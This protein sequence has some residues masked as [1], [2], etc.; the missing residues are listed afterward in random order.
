MKLG[1]KK[2]MSPNEKQIDEGDSNSKSKKSKASLSVIQLF[3]FSTMRDKLMILCA[4]VGSAYSGA[5]LPI[6]VIIFGDVMRKM[7]ESMIFKDTLLDNTRSMILELVYLGTS[8][9]VAT[10]VATAFWIISG[11]NQARRIRMK[12]LHAVLR[13][14]MS[15]FDS[16]EEG[17]LNTRLAGDTQTIQDGISE[18]FGTLTMSVAQF[19]SGYIVAFIKGWRMAL[20]ML[21][22][23]PLLLAS[24]AVMGIFITRFTLKVQRSYALA[25]TVAEQVFSGLRTVYSFS[26]QGRFAD[27]FERELVH[28]RKMGI[29]RGIVLGLGFGSFM[30]VLFLTYGLSF[31]Y[32]SRL[33]KQGEFDGATVLVV[34]FS[35]MMGSMAL[36]QLPPSLS[37]VSSAC[38][39]ARNIFATIDRVP[40]IDPDD[41]SFGS[42]TSPLQGE[43]EFKNVFFKYPTRPNL[44]ILKDLSLKIKQGM[45]VAF[46]GPSGSGKSTVIQL[47][48]RFYDPIAGQ[49]LL[50]GRDLRSYSVQSLRQQIGVV[51]QEPVLFN[52]TIKH[53]LL[54][55]IDDT[56]SVSHD[57][58]IEACKKAN[59]HGFIS[60]LP[61]GYNTLVGSGMLSGGQKQRVAIARA[62]LKN[63][64]LLLL[65]EATSALDTQSERLVQHALDAAAADRTTLVVAHRLSTIR[66][67]D[68]IVV[69]QQ[70]D[71]VEKGT[72]QELIELGGIYADL[73]K[74]QE[75]ATIQSSTDVTD[76]HDD[77]E[78]LL[79]QEK[80]ELYLNE[81]I[82][83]DQQSAIS[84]V[85]SSN[86]V[87]RM[88]T[89]SSVDAFQLK[90]KREKQDRKLKKAQKTPIFKVFRQMRS[91]WPLMFL[92]CLGAAVAGSIFP[93]FAYLFSQVIVILINPFRRNEIDQGPVQGTNFYAFFF[94]VMAVIA[95]IA[96][97]TQIISFEVAG[98]RYTERLRT[99]M[100]QAYMRQEVGYF[101]QEENNVGA[102]T[103]KIAVD[104]KNVNELVT[105]VWGD[106]TQLLVTVIVGLS[107]SFA[108]SWL[109]TLIVLCAAPFIV[110]ATGSETRVRQGYQDNTKKANAESGEVAGEAIKEIRTISALNKQSYFE[111]KYEKAIEYPHRLAV[112]KALLASIGQALVRGSNL[113]LN[114]LALYAGVRLIMD[115]WITFEEMFVVLSEIMT[116]AANAGRASV[117]TATF[118]KAKLSAIA[119]FDI[120]ERQPR[121]D[122]DLEGIEPKAV[123]GDVSFDKITFAYPARPDNPVF[124]GEFGFKGKANQTIALVGPSGCGKSTTIGMLLRWY[125]PIQG[126]V[127]LDDHSVD[128]YT[129][130]NLR[131]HMA[132]VQQEP[133]LFDMSIGDNIR[134][135]VEHDQQ[136]SQA[137]V[138]EACRAANIHKFI[139][140]LPLGYDTRVGDRGSQLSG[141]QK[142]RIAIARALIRKPKILLLDEATSALDTESEKLV[143]EAID[144]IVSEGGRTTLTIAHRLSTIQGSDMICVVKDGRV[145]EQGTH[146]E[147]LKLNGTYTDLV[148]QQALNPTS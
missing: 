76:L 38:G 8:V 6:S 132:I 79:Q 120:L 110:I 25:G 106:V 20:V 84:S 14:D 46:V 111:R 105:K 3:R 73:V 17:S 122:P 9:L 30:M 19:I 128:T 15:W 125:D 42:I 23:V 47:L 146:W 55:G 34:F 44:V 61:Q 5:I 131:H 2:D 11:E 107:I 80:Q 67:A 28:A 53:N 82:S 24:G 99:S 101:D 77:P 70:G 89:A 1:K 50:D 32:G 108:F 13:Q 83:D 75:V 109:L 35:M 12:Y 136:V 92:G 26:L 65:D 94:V 58:I 148:N 129:L 142:Q 54:M 31:W 140:G 112:R 36:T 147:L 29:K 56:E 69:M 40:A 10:Y 64:T 126:T 59:C 90:L 124:K 86:D 95:F 87:K 144:N 115:D 81:K 130:S 133:V 37:A 45:T 33:V 96:F 63:P 66:N 138:E 139:E 123:N 85:I 52:M 48:Q 62:I 121:I 119:A 127:R 100:F 41:H 118:A 141:G 43:I 97:S 103:T 51:G 16:S 135:G 18:E 4:I 57:D 116:T 98:E 137:Q 104:A 134:F 74:K 102:L 145:I 91:E 68:L 72:H 60:Q 49:V 71:L 114:A 88:S 143:Q 113:Y 7:G 21:A 93:T 39:A 78:L 27:I 22:T 117:F